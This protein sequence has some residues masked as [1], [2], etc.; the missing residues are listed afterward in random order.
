MILGMFSAVTPELRDLPTLI[1]QLRK[2]APLFWTLTPELG[3]LER[4]PQG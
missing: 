3:D 4:K 2:A 1:I